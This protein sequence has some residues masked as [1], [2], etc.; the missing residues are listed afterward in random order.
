MQT[1]IRDPL[2]PTADSFEF[3]T[4][5]HLD[6]QANACVDNR[7][8]VHVRGADNVPDRV[9]NMWRVELARPP[10]LVTVSDEYPDA[11]GP[12]THLVVLEQDREDRL[13]II[14]D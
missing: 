6:T 2:V 9:W 14:A 1:D 5:L 3:R 7:R 4:W 11:G 8:D 10:H 12:T 13:P